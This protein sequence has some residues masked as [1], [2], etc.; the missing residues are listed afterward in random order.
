MLTG[1]PAARSHV[2]PPGEGSQGELRERAIQWSCLR[3]TQGVAGY[4][5]NGQGFPTT[6][7]ESAFY[8]A[9]RKGFNARLHMP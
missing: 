6:D 3:Y 1:N 2:Y 7:C 5:S 4:D 9:F 8:E